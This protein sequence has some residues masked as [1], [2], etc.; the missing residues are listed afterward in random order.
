M[1]SLSSNQRHRI[2]QRLLSIISFWGLGVAVGSYFGLF[3]SFPLPWVALLVAMGITIPL[4]IY[5]GSSNFRAYISRT[6]SQLPNPLSRLAH[7]S[8][9]SLLLLR[10]SAFVAVNLCAKCSLGRFSSRSVGNRGFC[11]AKEHLEVL[12]L[13]PFRSSRFCGCG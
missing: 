12:G 7:S 8:G 10:Q 6:P 5:Y 11:I 2:S 4:T 9:P 13:S 1:V 3:S